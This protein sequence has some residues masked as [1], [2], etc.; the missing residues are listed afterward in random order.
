M[1]IFFSIKIKFLK[2][3]SPAILCFLTHA[4]NGLSAIFVFASLL[5]KGQFLKDKKYSFSV[6]FFSSEIDFILE[7]EGN[8]KGTHNSPP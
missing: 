4:Q 5:N 7:R 8:K 2:H 6:S 1:H 3:C